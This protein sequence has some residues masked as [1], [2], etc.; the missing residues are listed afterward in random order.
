MI[1]KL[2]RNPVLCAVTEAR[3]TDTWLIKPSWPAST[4]EEIR[5]DPKGA[6]NRSGYAGKTHIGVIV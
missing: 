1:R 2:M 4:A 5:A 6:V 3:A